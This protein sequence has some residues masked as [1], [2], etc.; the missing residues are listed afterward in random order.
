METIIKA[1][2]L[3]RHEGRVL[4]RQASTYWLLAGHLFLVNL[5]TLTSDQFF[6]TENSSLLPLFLNLAF[7]SCFF[8]PLLTMSVWARSTRLDALPWFFSFPLPLWSVVIARFFLT[9]GLALVT[10]ASTL[11]LGLTLQYLGSP[12]WGVIMSSFTLFAFLMAF[13]V[14]LGSLASAIA[15]HQLAAFLL[16][17]VANALFMALG[18]HLLF[19]D[20]PSFLPLAWTD[21]LAP[22]GVPFHLVA[23]FRGVI[24]FRDILFFIGWALFCLFINQAVIHHKRKQKRPGRNIMFGYLATGL[25]VLIIILFARQAHVRW[26]LTE[27]KLYTLSNGTRE[28]VRKLEKPI[29]ADLYFTR[30][31]SSSALKQYGQRIEELLREYQST[32]PKNFRLRFIDPVQDS[33]EEVRARIAGISAIPLAPGENIY[34]GLALRQG[35]QTLSIPVFTPQTEGQLEYELTEAI[36]KLVQAAKPS[37]G[38]MSELPLV[39]DELGGSVNLRNDWAFVAALRSLYQIVSVPIQ[40]E[41]LPEHLQSIIL[42]H[43]KQLSEKTLYAIDQYLMRGGKLMIFLDAFC[44]Y[45][46]NY[47]RATQ[48]HAMY[49]S[50]LKHFLD[51][52][53]V[54]FHNETLVGDRARSTQVAVAQISYDYPFQLQLTSQDMNKDMSIAKNLNK[55]QLLESGWL[56]QA[57]NPVKNLHYFPLMMSSE[58]SG[59]VRTEM[60]EYSSPQ[61]LATELKSDGKKRAVAALLRG[62]FQSTFDS[63][64]EGSL[65]EHRKSS[66]QDAAVVIV[67]DVDFLSDASVV[68]KV[69]SMGQMVYKPKGDNITFLM[70]SL[71]FISG[72]QDLIAIRS[73]THVDRSLWRLVDMEEKATIAYAGEDAALTS[74]LNE[75]QNKLAQWENENSDKG[76]VVS[77]EQLS[78]IQQLREE[79]AK[80]RRERKILKEKSEAKV[81]HLKANIRWLHLG[82]A[83]LTILL[84]LFWVLREK[85]IRS[86]RS[87]SDFLRSS[88]R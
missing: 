28:I 16:A 64:P 69:Q 25:G 63:V 61:D 51:A 62:R 18:S 34:L 17:A 43:P 33:E 88:V 80:L 46:I 47:P 2:I 86:T 57:A 72:H 54:I 70:N 49:S 50:Q 24:D 42:V 52:W 13:Q 39:G 73:R 38:I 31:H 60:T 9:W 59:L 81:R 53:G 6:N 5:L 56:E 85:P 10:L 22:L 35:D 74:K 37:I 27:E 71:E 78:M 19:E 29:Y 4:L 58:S 36:V 12:D 26:D 1:W 7:L 75:I 65:I 20:V 30:S 23:A 67:A 84:G 83:P 15:P 82:L 8:V 32:S 48:E 11:P 3:F 45:E 68:D 14:A 40:S 66:E 79:E 76:Q 21:R 41:A 87:V 55:V 44:R 77:R